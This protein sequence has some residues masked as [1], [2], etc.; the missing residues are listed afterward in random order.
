M[1]LSYLFVVVYKC[2]VLGFVELGTVLFRFPTA[3]SAF[4]LSEGL[5]IHEMIYSI[6]VENVGIFDGGINCTAVLD[7]LLHQR[8]DRFLGV[9]WRV[10][11]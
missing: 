11:F 4:L 3:T 10:F 2:I 5:V 7:V 1:R 8:S 6:R 9:L